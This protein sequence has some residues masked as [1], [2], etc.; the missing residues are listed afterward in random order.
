GVF[1]PETVVV[2]LLEGGGEHQPRDVRVDPWRG[3]FGPGAETYDIV[4]VVRR[5][6]DEPRR[7]RGVGRRASGHR[8]GIDLEIRIEDVGRSVATPAG[9]DGWIGAGDEIFH[10]AGADVP[11]RRQTVVR[12]PPPG[13]V[14][15]LPATDVP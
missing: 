13:D 2:R 15:H 11:L 12:R 7:F 5:D 10:R 6:T 3:Q 4:R 14:R 1:E 9:V 8:V